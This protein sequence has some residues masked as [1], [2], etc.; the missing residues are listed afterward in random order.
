MDD[1]GKVTTKYEVTSV[2][3]EWKYVERVLPPLV[4]PEPKIRDSYPSGWK[5][6]SPEAVN[7][8]YYIERTKNHMIPVY[9]HI[10]ERGNKKR[11]VVRKIKGDI[12]LLEKEIREFLQKDTLIPIFTQ[13]N[14]FANYIMVRGDHVNAIKYLLTKKGF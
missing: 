10:K 5:P 9:L 2:P 12:W 3:E 7:Q 14:E 4:V 1:I 11:T 8:P 13:V 6:Q